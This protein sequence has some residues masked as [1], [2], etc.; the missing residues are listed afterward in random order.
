[1]SLKG[2]ETQASTSLGSADHSQTRTATILG[3][4]ECCF[5]GLEAIGKVETVETTKIAS[6]TSIA[7]KT[8]VAESIGAGGTPVRNSGNTSSAHERLARDAIGD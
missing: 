7:C 5:R 8:D 4:R 6:S 3:I 2:R 1:M